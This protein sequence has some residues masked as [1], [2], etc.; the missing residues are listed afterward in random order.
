VV[1]VSKV[2]LARERGAKWDYFTLPNSAMR[3]TLSLESQFLVL[4]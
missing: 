2:V 1:P 3:P 4:P